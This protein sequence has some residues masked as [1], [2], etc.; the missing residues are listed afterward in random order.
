MQIKLEWYECALAAEAG[1]LRRLTSIQR[2][3]ANSHGATNLSWTEDIEGAAAE[4]AVA[5]ALGL[6]WGGEIDTFKSPDLPHGIQVR[7]TPNHANSLIV[8]KA[9]PD[10]DLYVLVTGVMP[11]FFIRGFLKG[12]EAKNSIWEKAPNGRPPA[13]FVSSSFLASISDFSK[14]VLSPATV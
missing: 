14:F 11:N 6:Y 8:R 2:E 7:W 4:L 5:K 9:D 1:K 13:Y 12:S 10:D 3:S